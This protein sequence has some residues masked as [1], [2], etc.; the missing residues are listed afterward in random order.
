MD[1]ETLH[2]VIERIKQAEIQENPYPYF[3]I[4]NLFPESFYQEMLAN[5][6]ET[7]NYTSLGDTGKV[8]SRIY[9]ERFVLPLKDA[10]LSTLSFGPLFFWS[11][12]SSALNSPE[13][14]SSLLE[15]FETEIK[16]RFDKHYENVKFSSFAELVRDKSNYSIGPHTDHP[17][18]VITLLFYLPRTKEHSHLGTSIYRPKDPSFSCEGFSHHG[19]DRFEKV[20]TMPFNPNSLLVFFKS[21]HSF[22]GVEPILEKNI[23]R[24]LLNHYIEW[25][26][27]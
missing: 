5:L 20:S 23:E 22:H 16:K 11:K 13:W 14:I 1:E 4:E 3:F 21:D 15:K 7:A 19:F 17:I 25:S 6:P 8:D 26:F 27:K 10:N 12:F 18:R 9:Q 2:Y 24:N